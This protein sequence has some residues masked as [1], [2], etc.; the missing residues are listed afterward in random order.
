M[1][2]LLDD[3]SLAPWCDDE[4]TTQVLSA[5]GGAIDVTALNYR[6]RGASRPYFGLN[7]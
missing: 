3:I 6:R 5:T 1:K 4:P 2:A 7:K